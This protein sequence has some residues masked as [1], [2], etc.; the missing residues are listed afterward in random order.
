MAASLHGSFRVG[1]GYS[2]NDVRDFIQNMRNRQTEDGQAYFQEAQL[3]VLALV[4]KRVCTELEESA[5]QK[6]M[7]RPLLWLVHGGPGVGKSETIKLVQTLFTDV[8]HWNIGINYQIAAL[9]AVMAEQLGG[10]TL[11]HCCGICIKN[12]RSEGAYSQGTK[13]QIEVDKAVLQWRWLIIDE[14]SMISSQL[15][16]EIDMA[17]RNIVRSN[18]S[19][20][21][22]AVG[23]VRPFGGINVLFVGDFWQLSPPK[24]GCLANLPIDFIKRARKYDAKPDSTHGEQL[25]WGSRDHAVQGV[26]E[27]TVSMR[28]EDPWLYEVQEE[29]RNGCLSETN[30]NFLHGRPTTVSGSW[31]KKRHLCGN[32]FCKNL[33]PSMNIQALECDMCK[34]ERAERCRVITGLEDTRLQDPNFVNAPAIFPNNDIKFAVN[35]IRAQIYAASSGHAIT[36]SQARD[37]GNSAVLADHPDIC[38]AKLQWLQR[39]DRDCGNL[40]GMLPLIVGMPVV[41]T[42]HLDRNPNINLLKGKLGRVDSWVEHE[43]EDTVFDSE[44]RILRFV[45][46]IVFVQY[47]TSV[48][49]ENKRCHVEKP[50]PWA[51]PGVDRPGIYPV[52][53]WKRSWYLDQHRQVPRLEVKRFQIPLAPAYAMTAHASQGRTLAAAII[54]LQLGRGVSIIASYVAMTRVRRKTDILIFRE[55]D[56]EVF[57]SGPPE[58]PTLLLQLLRDEKIDWS[59]IEDRLAPKKACKGPC[60]SLCFLDEFDTNEQKNRIDPHCKACVAKFTAAGTPNRC[61]RCRL[62]FGEDAFVKESQDVPLPKMTCR[63]C[64]QKEFMTTCIVCSELKP[65]QDFSP[66]MRKSNAH[67]RKCLACEKGFVCPGCKRVRRFGNF[68]KSELSKPEGTWLCATCMTRKCS[69]CFQLKTSKNFSS[70]Q[71]NAPAAR[72]LCATCETAL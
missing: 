41:L 36:W 43:K 67:K 35:K 8:L 44:K 40:Y 49:D 33:E 62:W 55:F 20:K 57:N 3:E 69:K 38:K 72:M 14:I 60:A 16:A 17:L 27:L 18:A 26:T 30:W 32:A 59:E 63:T 2:T 71:W 42:D 28:T 68:A 56:R 10:D 24:G 15:L 11:H 50:C 7:S 65:L 39:H 64:V 61:R 34:K 12:L 37:V 31:C 9:Q 46:R 45:P 70:A 19:G 51:I 22:S 25:F 29:M 52:F 47:Y 58:E 21:L 66:K 13:R 54:D 53:P 1:E 48:W 6:D 23:E 4:G 5:R